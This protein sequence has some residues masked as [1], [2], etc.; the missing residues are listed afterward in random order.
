M[1]K[2]SILIK[3]A[4]ESQWQPEFLISFAVKVIK[5]FLVLKSSG[6]CGKSASRQFCKGQRDLSQRTYSQ[7]NHAYLDTPFPPFL[8]FLCAKPE[9]NSHR[10]LVSKGFSLALAGRGFSRYTL[11]RALLLFL[12]GNPPGS[13]NDNWPRLQTG[14]PPTCDKPKNVCVG[15][16]L[17]PADYRQSIDKYR[18]SV[19]ETKTVSAYTPTGR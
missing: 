18:P 13:G 16:S 3:E 4:Y 15:G 2:S 1:G 8:V 19:D 10:Q 5:V 12:Y 9:G 7:L 11:R 17:K 6:L 14:Q